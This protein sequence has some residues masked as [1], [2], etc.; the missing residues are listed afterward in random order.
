MH[1]R[2]RPVESWVH[3]MQ[4]VR[5][6][7]PFLA[8]IHGGCLLPPSALGLLLVKMELPGVYPRRALFGLEAEVDEPVEPE[9]FIALPEEGPLHASMRA[10][11][12]RA[13]SPME[14]YLLRGRQAD[15]KPVLARRSSAGPA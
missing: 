15:F 4:G 12:V 8:L 11:C 1:A 14:P 10:P 6:P 7:L 9:V 3:P 13:S 5:S 2:I